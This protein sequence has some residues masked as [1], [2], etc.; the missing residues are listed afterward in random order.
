MLVPPPVHV[1]R[2]RPARTRPH[3]D[4]ALAAS[5]AVDPL[6]QPDPGRPEL[7]LVRAPLTRAEPAPGRDPWPE[8][9]AP[10][11]H[12]DVD[13]DAALRTWE[14]GRRVEREQVRL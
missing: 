8:L 10:A 4:V 1:S 14:R 11:A 7:A 12:G 3:A 5:A 9:P 13:T 6:A 2:A